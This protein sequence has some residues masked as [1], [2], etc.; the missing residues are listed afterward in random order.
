MTL[1]EVII[2]LGLASMILLVSA[3][4]LLTALRSNDK[5][6]DTT[7]ASALAQETAEAFIYGLP[8]SGDPFWAAT[9]FPSPY[10]VDN[11]TLGT[12]VF[13][14]QINV[15]DLGAVSSGLRQVVV[16]ISWDNGQNG[17][18]GY[19]ILN[20]QVARLVAEP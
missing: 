3:D 8:P 16:Q 13:H 19:G 5:G 6:T 17:R 1:A 18:T 11:V 12:Q 9:S 2:A 20:A 14:R 4:L 10:Q 7:T 15:A